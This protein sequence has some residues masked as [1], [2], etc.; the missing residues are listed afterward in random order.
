LSDMVRVR[1][2]A[3]ASEASVSDSRREGARGGRV[4]K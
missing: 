4:S 3:P 1:V 2:S